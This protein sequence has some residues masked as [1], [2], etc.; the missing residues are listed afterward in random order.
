M[1][2]FQYKDNA[3][4]PESIIVLEVESQT[5]SEADK[6]FKELQGEDIR[7]IFLISCSCKTNFEAVMLPEE[8][9]LAIQLERLVYPHSL[10]LLAAYP[11]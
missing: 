6:W 1:K 8:I 10:P 3:F 5:I 2:I 11:E 9:D 4:Y 7:K